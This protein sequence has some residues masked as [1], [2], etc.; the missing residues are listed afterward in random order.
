LAA[1]IGSVAGRR[2]QPAA[3]SQA[4]GAE[5]VQADIDDDGFADRQRE[6]AL[7]PGQPRGAHAVDLDELFGDPL[8]ALPGR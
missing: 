7:L 6:P 4:A 1:T 5:R 3:T 8:A 2:A